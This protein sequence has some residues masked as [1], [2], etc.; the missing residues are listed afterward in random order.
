MSNRSLKVK[1]HAENPLCHW[2]QRETK[3]TNIQ[4]IKG[5]PDPLM[6][7]VDHIISRLNPH[8]WVKKNSAEERRKVL[9]CFECN[10]KRSQVEVA[11]LS[12]QEL[13]LRGQGFSLSPK[14]APAFTKP[15]ASVEEVVEHV[16][17]TNKFL[18]GVAEF[19]ILKESH[20][21]A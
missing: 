20:V 19:Q 8:R 11:A 14:G 3:L 16:Q 13:Y 4:H 6:A 7:T 17:K 1:L 12:K 2:C 21:T 9:A 10:S 5:Q 15:V 18:S